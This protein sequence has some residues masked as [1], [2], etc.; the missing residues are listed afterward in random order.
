MSEVTK[1]LI[2]GATCRVLGQ[3]TE[4]L[5]KLRAFQNTEAEEKIEQ[6]KKNSAPSSGDA[7]HRADNGK[8]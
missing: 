5:P 8:S 3:D 6:L 2:C 1:C 4:G 7:S